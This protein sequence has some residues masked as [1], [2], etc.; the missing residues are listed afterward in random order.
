MAKLFSSQVA[1]SITSTCVDLYGGYGFTREYPVE[2]F[3]RDS[4]IG[5]STRHQ[6][7]AAPDDRQG[8]DQVNA[9]V[10]GLREAAPHLYGYGPI[11]FREREASFSTV[12]LLWG[13]TLSIM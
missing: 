3:Y 5:R 12:R 10:N 6:Q 13:L 7:H 11:S 2:K 9:A 4:K 1:Q 8:A